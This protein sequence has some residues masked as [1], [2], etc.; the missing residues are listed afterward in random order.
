MDL[1]S[2]LASR[3]TAQ[4]YLAGCRLHGNARRSIVV[5][6]SNGWAG[7]YLT[8]GSGKIALLKYD[9]FLFLLQIVTNKK[10]MQCFRYYGH[11]PGRF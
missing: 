2:N 1:S 3:F 11:R 5:S 4:H 8:L 6:Q 10:K 7:G 9:S